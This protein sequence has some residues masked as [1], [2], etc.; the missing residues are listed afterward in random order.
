MIVQGKF[1]QA[2][3]SETDTT[4]GDQQFK[5]QPVSEVVATS[6]AAMLCSQVLDNCNP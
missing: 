4:S 5:L 1:L 2:Q 3:S 6:L